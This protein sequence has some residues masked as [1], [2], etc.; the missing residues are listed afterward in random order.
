MDTNSFLNISQLSFEL[1]SGE[2][3][4]KFLIKRFKKWIPGTDHSGQTF[5]SQRDL[6]TLILILDKINKGILPSTIEEELTKGTIQV[7]PLDKDL[8]P[9]NNNIDLQTRKVKA[10]EK[11]ANAEEKKASAF[12]KSI[13][14]ETLKIKALNN[15]ANAISN[16]NTVIP[17]FSENE[18]TKNTYRADDLSKLLDKDENIIDNKKTDAQID[19][20]SRLIDNNLDKKQEIEVEIDNLASL[21]DNSQSDNTELDDLSLLIQDKKLTGINTIDI[22]DLSALL[23]VRSSDN[24]ELDD[25]SL[26]LEDK[27]Q[28]NNTIDD[29]SMLIKE[30]ES[31]KEAIDDLSILLQGEES[32][33]EG[34]DDLSALIDFKS[35]N[36]PM[37]QKPDFSPKDDFENYKSEII[38]IIIDLKNQGSTKE[39]TCERFNQEGILT[40]S[41]KPKWSIKTISQIYQLINNAA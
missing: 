24:Y 28:N 15:I 38:N 31:K 41:G 4:I 36:K 3:I 13:E 33:K 39:E 9:Q 10:L 40:L 12:E 22:D 32:K 19:D 29:L 20:L 21:L 2:A 35:N 30:K 26:L 34:I 11:R 7:L 27:E 23:D 6:I 18:Q 14:I 1:D 5:Y 17:Q 25:L 37:I 8:S 16:F